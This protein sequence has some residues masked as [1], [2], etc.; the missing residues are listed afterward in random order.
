MADLVAACRNIDNTTY[1]YERVRF[2]RDMLIDLSE[3]RKQARGFGSPVGTAVN[4]LLGDASSVRYAQAM[5]GD[6][7]D[8]TVP[9]DPHAK[10][11]LTEGELDD[12]AERCIVVGP[13]RGVRGLVPSA[14]SNTA[15]PGWCQ[16]VVPTGTPWS[17]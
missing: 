9:F 17:T 15:T 8:A 2:L 3:Y 13:R 1:P 11:E 5:V 10:I 7:T 14:P 16:P 12:L 6:P 4:V